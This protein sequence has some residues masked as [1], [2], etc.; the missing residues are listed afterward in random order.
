MNKVNHHG[1]RF[2]IDVL[3]AGAVK[4]VLQQVKCFA[5]NSKF[6]AR[7]HIHLNGVSVVDNLQRTRFVI[8]HYVVAYFFKRAFDVQR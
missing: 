1:R 2:A 8:W 3:F 5:I 7:H 6:A 4:M